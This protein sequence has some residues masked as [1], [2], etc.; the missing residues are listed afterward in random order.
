MIYDLPTTVTVGGVDYAVRTDY[1]AILDVCLA[2][3]DAE[4]TEN[5]RVYTAMNIFY[6]QFDDIPISDYEEAAKMLVWFVNCGQ[7]EAKGK[8][9]KLVD[10]E[11][12]YSYIV[13]PIN[14]VAGC[15]IRAMEYL[16]WWTFIAYYYEIGGDC[17]FAQIV[18][19][20]DSLAKGKRLDKQDREW[21]R[22]NGHLVRFKE[23]YT[24]AENEAINQWIKG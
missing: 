12:D 5:E 7:D 13:A 16:H 17:V 18:R 10:W 23:K 14:R 9:P 15:E 11:Q 21:L 24:E 2:L 3:Q 4:L 1:R 22:K 20:R 6:P 8:Q 19:I